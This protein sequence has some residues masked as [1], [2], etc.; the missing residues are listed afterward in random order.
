M[1]FSNFITWHCYFYKTYKIK[2]KIFKLNE[3]IKLCGLV[4]HSEIVFF[5]SYCYILKKIKFVNFIKYA[6]FH[7]DILF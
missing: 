1:R 5:K 3:K 2:I 4:N 7:C 6:N